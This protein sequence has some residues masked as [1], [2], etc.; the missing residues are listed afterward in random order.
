[1]VCVRPMIHVHR[2]KNIQPLCNQHS[3]MDTLLNTSYLIIFPKQQFLVFQLG[4]MHVLPLQ[5]LGLWN[6]SMVNPQ[7]PLLKELWTPLHYLPTPWGTEIS[8]TNPWP[9]LLISLIWMPGR[10]CRQDNFGLTISR[11]T[12]IVSPASLTNELNHIRRSEENLC[13]ILITPPDKSMLLCFSNEQNK[14]ALFDSHQHDSY[15]GLIAV[16]T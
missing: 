5:P 3:I 11:D 12:G 6:F 14:I 16:V 4:A 9:C 8:I 15:G 10:P 7:C 13:A 1:M 2:L